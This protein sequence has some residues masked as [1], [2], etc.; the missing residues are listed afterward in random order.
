MRHSLTFVLTLL[1]LVPAAAHAQESD[2]RVQYELEKKNEFAAGAL[3]WLIPIVGHHY[4]GD[5]RTGFVPAAVSGGGLV[6]V[7]LGAT[8]K[9]DCISGGGV[10]ICK[11]GN[12]TVM[13]L[14]WVT[15][16]G[17]RV[18]GIVSALDVAKEFNR[19]LADRL[20]VGLDDVQLVVAP[21]QG[22][23]SVGLSFPIG[24]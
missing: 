3:E 20:G 24:R 10:E 16:L 1:L 12:G 14:G 9:S 22:R 7:I 15:Y 23:V 21:S 5:A 2:A 19:D 13:A 6:G 18:W 8:L 17:G 4:A 11:Q